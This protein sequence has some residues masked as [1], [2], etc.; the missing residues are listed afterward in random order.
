MKRNKEYEALCQKWQGPKIN[1]STNKSYQE[2]MAFKY[3]MLCEKL[4]EFNINK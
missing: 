4:N 2:Y 1:L 3:E